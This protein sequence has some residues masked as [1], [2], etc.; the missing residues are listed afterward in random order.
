M[1]FKHQNS[2]PKSE[3]ICWKN[4]LFT[5]FIENTTLNCLGWKLLDCVSGGFQLILTQIHVKQKQQKQKP[6]SFGPFIFTGTLCCKHRTTQYGI[7]RLAPW[8]IIVWPAKQRRLLTRIC[9]TFL[10][11]M[12][13]TL[14]KQTTA[15]NWHIYLLG[16]LQ[17]KREMT[18]LLQWRGIRETMW[19]GVC[20]A[21]SS[22]WG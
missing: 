2:E 20:L 16:I 14:F 15:W 18:F 8:I 21:S 10:A 19:W 11:F 4:Y 7:S 3:Q 22:R 5:L 6:L 1:L 17:H 13:T 12:T 9:H